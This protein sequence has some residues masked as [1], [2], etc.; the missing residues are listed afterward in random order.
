MEYSFYCGGLGGLPPGAVPCLFHCAV[1]DYSLTSLQRGD[2]D[3]I[4]IL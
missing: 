1:H 2:A 3:I 4:G